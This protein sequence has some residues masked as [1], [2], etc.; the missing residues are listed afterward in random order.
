MQSAKTL[1]V[2]HSIIIKSSLPSHPPRPG[3]KGD[4]TK[5][6]PTEEARPVNLFD[7]CDIKKSCNTKHTVLNGDLEVI[8]AEASVVLVL[9]YYY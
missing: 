4:G 5:A 2:T 9:S 8:A 3:T 7:R 6:R 1:L